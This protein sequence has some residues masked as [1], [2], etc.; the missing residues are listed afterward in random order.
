MMMSRPIS[1][2]APDAKRRKLIVANADT[3]IAAS[4]DRCEEL[5][6]IVSPA[7]YVLAAFGAN[8]YTVE[9]IASRSQSRMLKP[10]K[11]MIE[12]YTIESLQAVRGNDVEK[13]KSLNDS[14][15]CLQCCNRFG[16]SLIHLASRRGL[17]KV[18]EF[19]VQEAKV[20]LYLADDFGRNPLH[21][22]CWRPEPN[23]DLLKLL[24]AEAPEL[25][26][27]T[28]VRGYTPFAYTRKSDWTEWIKF[29][30]EHKD[31]LRPKKN[32][33]AP[34]PAPPLK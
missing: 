19:L 12:H 18:M 4:S 21:D 34:P 31:L 17:T 32:P 13:L 11:E 30:A 8:G 28:D 16:E 27:M 25:L 15:K 26:C 29:L 1:T 5:E 9:D 2:E 23:F 33:A 22:A 14:G 7:D 6:G 24:I 10:S 3:I 20:S